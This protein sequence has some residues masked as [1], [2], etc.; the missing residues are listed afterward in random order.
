MEMGTISAEPRAHLGSKHTRRMRKS[1]KMPAIIYGHGE[2]PE[3]ITI[4]AHEAENLL[5]H[6]SR[7]IELQLGGKKSSFLIKAV[8]YDY[9]GTNP[10][11]LDLMRVDLNERIQVNVEIELRG[12]AK[13]EDEGG[14]VSQIL[15]A[16][17]VECLITNI[18]ESIRISVADMDIN[19][20]LLVKDL[21]MPEGVTAITDGDEQIAVCRVPTVVEETEEG[22]EGEESA[23]P[24]VIGR[25]KED[26]ES[27]GDDK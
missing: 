27:A 23:T 19:D 5:D 24:E 17:E 8:Q 18:P 14:V 20:D 25:P 7:V 22:E 16:I 4:D 3:P 15:N 6:H 10:I 9:L 21:E 2:K 26:E 11:H 12:T 13:G 1:G